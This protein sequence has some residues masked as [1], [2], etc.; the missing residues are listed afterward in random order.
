MLNLKFRQSRPSFFLSRA[1][2]ISSPGRSLKL[3]VEKSQ[4]YIQKGGR[5]KRNYTARG[6]CGTTPARAFYTCSCGHLF[7][8]FTAFNKSTPL[9]Q[10][11]FCHRCLGNACVRELPFTPASSALALITSRCPPSLCERASETFFVKS[12]RKSRQ[13]ANEPIAHCQQCYFSKHRFHQSSKKRSDSASSS[14]LTL[15]PSSTG[16]SGKNQPPPWHQSAPN[17]SAALIISAFETRKTIS[18]FFGGSN[19]YFEINSLVFGF[20]TSAYRRNFSIAF[21]LAAHTPTCSAKSSQR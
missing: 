20:N 3:L 15:Q 1:L 7:W 5:A 12:N 8:R 11:P 18:S 16:D 10:K 6:H 21:L 14:Q 4:Y 9:L 19:S 13:S 2:S 17:E